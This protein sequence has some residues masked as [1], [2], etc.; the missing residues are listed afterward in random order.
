MSSKHEPTGGAVR[1]AWIAH[2]HDGGYYGRRRAGIIT[3]LSAKIGPS[4]SPAGEG[5]PMASTREWFETVEEARRRA[6]RRLPRSVYLSLVAGTEQGITLRDNVAA[7]S[8][9]RFTPPHIADLPAARQLATS[10]LG[11]EISLP[12]IASPTGVQA[13]HPEGEVGVARGTAEAG[14]ADGPELLRQHAGGGRRGGEP[15]AVLPG[16]LVRQQGR[17]RAA[18]RAG[19]R[20]RRQ[21]PDRHPGLVVLQ[22]PGLGQPGHPGEDG[23]AGHAAAG[24]GGPDPARATSASGC[25][26]AA[27]P[28]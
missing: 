14:T 7:F 19:P 11:Q 8:E 6:R 3:A 23:P 20:G 12:V 2:G 27:C 16:L 24:P 5:G 22:R 1:R 25:A 26:R 4:G 18:D 28:T 21:G 9:L 13:V 15:E 17:D 10:V